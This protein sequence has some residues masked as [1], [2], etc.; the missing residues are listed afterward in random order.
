MRMSEVRHVM[1]DES[2]T[3]LGIGMCIGMRD[4]ALRHLRGVVGIAFLVPLLQRYAACCSVVLSEAFVLHWDGSGEENE[5]IRLRYASKCLSELL[6]ASSC[7][8]FHGRSPPSWSTDLISEVLPLTPP[9]HHLPRRIPN[10]NMHMI[11]TPHTLQP[12]PIL[13]PQYPLPRFSS[14]NP[15]ILSQFPHKHLVHKL[16]HQNSSLRRQIPI[17]GHVYRDRCPTPDEQVCE[18]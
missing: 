2:T 1:G 9:P 12:N 8:A 7:E 6:Y 5:C 17:P 11:H 13:K 16:I 15:L 3:A 4:W 14:R 18:A 10:N